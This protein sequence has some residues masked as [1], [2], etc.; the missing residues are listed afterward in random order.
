LVQRPGQALALRR[1]G[2]AD[3][4]CLV[5]LAQH[6]P[7]R[8]D[9]KEQVR[10]GVAAGGIVTPIRVCGHRAESSQPASADDAQGELRGQ[11]CCTSR[12]I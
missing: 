4:F 11:P 12:A 5:D 1:T 10:I 6:G 8:A 3:P 9:R 2:P 7:G